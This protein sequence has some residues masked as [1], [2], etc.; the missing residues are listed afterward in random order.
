MSSKSS[1]VIADNSTWFL[2]Y[3]WIISHFTEIPHFKNP[4]ISWR[5]VYFLPIMNIYIQIFM[6]IFWSFLLGIYLR[7]ELLVISELYCNMSRNSQI[8]SKVSA[9]WYT[10]KN[11]HKESIIGRQITFHWD[12]VNPYTQMCTW[13]YISLSKHTH[14]QCWGELG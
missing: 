3:C 7:I 1:H 13:V 14:L 2:F 12:D 9:W 5:V 11:E 8:V 10:C 4:S 6:W